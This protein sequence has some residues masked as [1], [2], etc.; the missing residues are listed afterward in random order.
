[1]DK[2]ALTHG[3]RGNYLELYA[4]IKQINIQVFTCLQIIWEN[5]PDIKC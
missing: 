2:T 4:Y 3:H 5:H 1:M